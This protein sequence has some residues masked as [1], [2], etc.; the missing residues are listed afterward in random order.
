M[1]DEKFR[2]ERRNRV[3][4]CSVAHFPQSINANWAAIRSTRSA[5]SSSTAHSNGSVSREACGLRVSSTVCKEF[6]VSAC[7]T[8]DV[9]T[10]ELIKIPVATT[11]VIGLV[12]HYCERIHEHPARIQYYTKVLKGAAQQNGRVSQGESRVILLLQ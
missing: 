12:E 7:L 11:K 1:K 9:E 2:F 6:T 10:K 8:T 4:I 5:R 3:E